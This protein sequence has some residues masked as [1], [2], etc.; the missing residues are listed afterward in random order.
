MVAPSKEVR[1][2]QSTVIEFF[3]AEGENPAH[4][5]KRLKTVYE[6]KALDCSIVQRW[7][8]DLNLNSTD[9]QYWEI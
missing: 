6:D 7:A 8:R 9:Q 1:R 5:H 2:K 4:L 3:V